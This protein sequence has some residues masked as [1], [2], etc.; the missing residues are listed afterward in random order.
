MTERKIFASIL[1]P[2]WYS[3]R[4]TEWME[5][6][7][8][9]NTIYAY[10]KHIW[11]QHFL[12]SMH[13]ITHTLGTSTHMQKPYRRF[14][15]TYSISFA[16]NTS[17]VM[18]HCGSRRLDTHSISFVNWDPDILFLSLSV[19]GKTRLWFEYCESVSVVCFFVHFSLFL[20]R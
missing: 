16:I 11:Q 14:W 3:Q 8:R 19:K 7:E 1:S 13:T 12:I 15:I 4:L 10:S 17:F 9:L 5:W 2:N 6:S 18:V 20:C